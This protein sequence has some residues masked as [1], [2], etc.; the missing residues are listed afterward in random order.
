MSYILGN[1]ELFICILLFSNSIYSQIISSNSV[2]GFKDDSINSFV[3]TSDYHRQ[4]AGRIIFSNAPIELGKER[5]TALLDSFTSKDNIWGIIYLNDS[6][7]NLTESNKF[8]V[9]QSIAIDGI[10]TA[11]YSF[12]MLPEKIDQSFLKTEIIVPPEKALTKGVKTYIR[13][14]SGITQGKHDVKVA[15]RIHDDTVAVGNFTL[16]CNEGAERI[17]ELNFDYDTKSMKSIVMPKPAVRDIFLEADILNSV[18][19]MAGT[20]QK[21]SII[22]NGWTLVKNLSGN[23]A[24]RTINAAVGFGKPDGKCTMTFISFRQD[25]DGKNYGKTQLYSVGNSYD[26]PCENVMK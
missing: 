25:Y 6:F 9:V 21:V 19:D 8:E 5:N 10:E 17:K 22:D 14:L 20:A 15:V 12:R 23:I 1:I 16:D 24:F 18:K 7:K 3:Y 13:G 2:P 11:H 4:N 26:I